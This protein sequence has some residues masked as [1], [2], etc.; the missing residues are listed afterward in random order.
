[1]RSKDEAEIGSEEHLKEL[2]E[3]MADNQAAAGSAEQHLRN[4]VS[5][6]AGLILWHEVSSHLDV[7]TE[8]TQAAKGDQE[9]LELLV[10]EARW[11]CENA[12]PKQ[13]VE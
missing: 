13:E 11:L 2:H 5:N 7:E 8:R 6:I 4:W 12:M 9:T 10:Y 1:M 3:L